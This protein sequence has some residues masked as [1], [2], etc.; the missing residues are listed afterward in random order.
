[1]S[2]G[3]G[4]DDPVITGSLVAFHLLELALH[5]TF[6]S[7][8]GV[9]SGISTH[10]TYG[11]YPQFMVSNTHPAFYVPYNLRKLCRQI[12]VS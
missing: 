10:I 8:F 1:M 4:C 6:Y 5:L 7:S 11:R 9:L 3:G 2:W 12:W